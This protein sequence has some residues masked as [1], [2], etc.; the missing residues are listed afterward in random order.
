MI[1]QSD[2]H[3]VK[4]CKQASLCVDHTTENTI[5]LDIDSYISARYYVI[6]CVLNLE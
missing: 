2:H 6:N 1:F 3:I 5:I 4:Q